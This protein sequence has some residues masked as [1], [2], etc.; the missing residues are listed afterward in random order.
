MDEPEMHLLNPAPPF[1]NS[2]LPVLVYQGAL[3]S[4]PT[5]VEALYARHGLT[6]AWRN[7]VYP[8]HH[9]HSSAH[10]VL[11][12]TRGHARLRLGGPDG[13]LLDATPGI[14]LV[15]PAG[16]SHCN[17][18]SSPD[19]QVVGATERTSPRFP[20]RAPTPS[21]GRAGRCPV[22]GAARSWRNE[23]GTGA[24]RAPGRH[25]RPAMSAPGRPS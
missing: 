8:F 21:M 15:I 11:G 5:D 17:E 4:H 14:V 12:C 23:V 13:L 1:P 16:V 6:A 24:G 10:E 9:W 25:A 2:P 18:G 7:G 20:S 22:S 3:P 19:F